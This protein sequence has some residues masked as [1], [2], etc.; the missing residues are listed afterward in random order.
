MQT[1]S[2]LITL[3]TDF[4]LA[5]TYVG[6]MKGVILGIAPKARIVDLTHE[7]S[8][9]NIMEASIRLESAVDFFPDGTVHLVVVDP[10]VGS[11]R[12][13]IVVQTERAIFV[14]P[15]NGVL[16]F[17]LAHRPIR[18]AVCM[19]D[20]ALPYCL[21]PISRTFHGRDVFASIAAHIASGLP[22]DS[23]GRE[24]Q[25]NQLIMLP[26]SQPEIISEDKNHFR[27]DLHIV[28]SDRFGNLI[29]DMTQSFWKQ[30]KSKLAC[31]NSSNLEE[32]I[33]IEAGLARIQSIVTTYASVELGEPLAYWGSAGRLEI[34]IRNGNAASMLGL[35]S[36]DSIT[37]SGSFP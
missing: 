37:I 5:D 9:Q 21:Q 36:G 24:V 4:G 13:A 10:G 2:P 28:Y 18:K 17:I 29:T 33:E 27:M 3:T 16:T 8:P 34:G 30:I 25:S 6:V 32:L 35:T 31:R 1:H 22:L 15:D 12:D 7:I 11:E 20:R 19:D 14:A 23:I 26:I